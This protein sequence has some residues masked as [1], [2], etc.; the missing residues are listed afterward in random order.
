MGRIILAIVF[1]ALVGLAAWL[2]VGEDKEQG[3]R[4]FGGRAVTVITTAADLREFAD[5]VEALGTARARESVVITSPV[6]D[7]V[8]EVAFED[9]QPVL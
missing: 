6:T 2:L 7:I 4:G 5:L 3:R 8:E 1:A 9:G